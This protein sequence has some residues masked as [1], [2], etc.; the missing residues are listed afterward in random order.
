MIVYKD[1]CS[2]C[3]GVGGIPCNESLDSKDY[4]IAG[5]EG[6]IICP[7]CKGSGTV[8]RYVI[9]DNYDYV[10]PA[11]REELF[12]EVIKEEMYA[13]GWGLIELAHYSGCDMQTMFQLINKRR[14]LSGDLARGLSKAFETSAEFWNNLYNDTINTPEGND[15]K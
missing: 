14:P 4:H 7:R 3:D 12:Y 1:K 9:G 10:S 8:T 2:S 13:R 6:G 15:A 11:A 5:G